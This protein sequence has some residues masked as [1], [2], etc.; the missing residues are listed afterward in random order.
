MAVLITGAA[1]LVGHAVRRRL[2]ADVHAGGVSGPM[3]AAD[4]PV[5]GP[6]DDVEWNH[7]HP[8]GFE[9]T[10][11]GVAHQTGGTGDQDGHAPHPAECPTDSGRR[12]AAGLPVP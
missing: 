6:G 10:T 1:G 8:L 2:E 12:L 11:H 4:D 9:P 7:R 3:V 5:V